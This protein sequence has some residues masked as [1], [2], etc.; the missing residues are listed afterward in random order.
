MKVFLFG[1]LPVDYSH[2]ERIK[3]VLT[4]IHTDKKRIDAIT[5]INE[6]SAQIFGQEWARENGVP[7]HEL[8]TRGLPDSDTDIPRGILAGRMIKQALAPDDLFLLL[9]PDDAWMQ[10]IHR[11][12]REKDVE[13]LP[14]E[15]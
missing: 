1:G 11:I 10:M 13:V 8:D 7:V 15:V 9:P 12:G 5:T 3:R 2:S 6:R 14:I 4:N